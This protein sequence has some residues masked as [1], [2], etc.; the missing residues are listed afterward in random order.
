MSAAAE[1]PHT[2]RGVRTERGARVV[3]LTSTSTR[4]LDPRLDVR[5]HSPSG[6]EWGYGGSGPAQLALALCIDV[7]G[8]DVERARR[9]YQDVKVR[10]IAGWQEDEWE[11]WREQLLLVIEAIEARVLR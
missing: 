2:Y 5:N 6:F 10:L 7:L 1:L 3:A 8:G 4:P 11:L 9:V